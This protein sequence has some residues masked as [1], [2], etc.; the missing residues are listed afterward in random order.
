MA[1]P[2]AQDLSTGRV[3]TRL[4]AFTL[5]LVLTNFLQTLHGVTDILLTGRLLGKT[6]MSAV[7]IGGQSTLFL[8]TFSLGLAAGGQILIAQLKGAEKRKEQSEATIAL[9]TL[10]LGIG[11]LVALLGFFIAPPALRLLQTPED[12]FAG[13]LQYMRITSIGLVFTF[14]YNAIAGALRGRGD[15]RRPLWFAVI[16]IGLHIALGILFVGAWSMGIPGA[17]LAAVIAQ[18]GAVLLGA[19]FLR[20]AYRSKVLLPPLR[21]LI[22]I[23]KI[24]VPFGLQMGLLNLSNLFIVRLV[25]PYGVA[26]SAALGV[27]SR[28]TNLLIVPMLAIG[29]GAS[30]MIGQSLG[31]QK[32]RRATAAVRWAL[33]YTLIFVSLTT[34]STLLFPA[35]FLGI[36][37]SEAEVIRIGT[38]YLTTLAWG[39]TGHALHTSFN[40][41]IL[42]AGMTSHSLLAAGA[43]AL[44][45]RIA[46]TWLCSAYWM[47][48]GIFLAQAIAPYLAAALSFAF[49]LSG[50]WK[51]HRLSG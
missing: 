39:Y 14:L 21:T 45:G 43:E 18:A 33:I 30:T 28:I 29:N 31:A 5:P 8:T 26:A 2:V 19:F 16:G 4:L 38:V 6:A 17:A 15:S 44:I 7:T 46:L 51:H 35:V 47:L 48:S 27:G 23:L 3:S 32:P 42:G 49:F 37:T 20:K 10:S 11:I 24:G 36:F 40:A 50:R 25:N 22:Q 12:A 1:T 34:A 41:A 9:F 13:A